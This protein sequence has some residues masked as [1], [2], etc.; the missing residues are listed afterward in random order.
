MENDN[1]ELEKQNTDLKEELK[2]QQEANDELNQAHD[3]LEKVSS[4]SPASS[5]ATRLSPLT[6][7]Q[8]LI[9]T[10]HKTIRKHEL[11]KDMQIS[12]ADKLYEHMFQHLRTGWSRDYTSH[13]EQ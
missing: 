8:S 1:T 6:R 4:L 3:K 11:L 7:G 10:S 12:G 9:G 13:R 5:D 2:S